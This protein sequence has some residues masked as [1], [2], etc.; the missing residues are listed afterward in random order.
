MTHFAKLWTIVHNSRVHEK[1]EDYKLF[2]SDINWNDYGYYTSFS[3]WLQ[4]QKDKNY[5]LKIA[6]L[7]ILNVGQKAGASPVISNESMF[8]FVRDIK[9][10]Y[11]ILFHLTYKERKELIASLNIVFRCDAVK[12][13]PAFQKSVLRGTNEVNFKI[14]QEKIESIITCPLDISTALQDNK[15]HLCMEW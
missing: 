6:D 7:N 9:S 3:L 10:A 12:N 11:L 4:L 15:E 13:E 14:L 5:N 8:T 2:L 1:F